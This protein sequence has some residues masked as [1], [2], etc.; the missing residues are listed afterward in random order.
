MC[1]MIPIDRHN[2]L[3][4]AKKTFIVVWPSSLVNLKLYRNESKQN[5][6]SKIEE[7]FHLQKNSFRYSKCIK[8]D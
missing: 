5:M 8:G 3:M 2:F 1:N 7:S 4:L 6:L